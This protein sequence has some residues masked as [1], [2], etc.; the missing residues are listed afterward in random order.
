MNQ[1]ENKNILLKRYEQFFGKKYSTNILNLQK[2]LYKNQY[3]RVN[4][5]KISKIKVEKFLKQNR[6]KFENTIIENA[7]KINKSFFNLSSSIFNL[8]GQI[9]LQNLA[10]QFPIALLISEINKNKKYYEILEMASSPGSKTT[11]VATLF[12]YHNIA[13]E[14]TCI[15]KNPKR[16]TRLINNIQ[17]QEIENIKIL[18][19][20]ARDYLSNSKFDIILLDAPCSGNLIEDRNWLN[21]RDLKGIK[22]NQILQKE[23][24]EIANNQLKKNGILIYST[25]SLEPEEN[26]LNCIW[27][28]NNLDLKSYFPNTKLNFET[29]PSK[30]FKDKKILKQIEKLKS[31]RLNPEISGT[32]GFF[33][34]FFK[35]I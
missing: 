33:M 18:N 13:Y 15:E 4:Q 7:I 23:L 2:V 11:Q 25:C 24:L 16:L 17:K 9:Y 12:K 28:Q 31:I 26:E 22:E 20:D 5:N 1:I 21:K 32:Q 34:C 27:A 29:N 10:S 30:I 35:K 14:I 3:L 19:I 8:T 6:V